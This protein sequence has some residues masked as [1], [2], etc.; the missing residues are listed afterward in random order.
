MLKTQAPFTRQQIRSVSQ[1]IL[2][3]SSPDSERLHC[4][5]AKENQIL[6]T[7]L[8]AGNLSR[9]PCLHECA[10]TQ[11]IAIYPGKLKFIPVKIS[12][13]SKR[14]HRIHAEENQT[15]VTFL[16]AGNLS[17]LPCSH[18]CANTQ[19]I[20]IYPGKLK[21]IPVKISPDSERLQGRHAKEMC[22]NTERIDISFAML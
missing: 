12:L 3:K 21:F 5:H 2:V 18:E 11:R 14:L 8:T 10:N 20:A 9:L 7:F 16:T 4:R 6:V 1:F 13:D 19:R 15:L 22:A 17:E